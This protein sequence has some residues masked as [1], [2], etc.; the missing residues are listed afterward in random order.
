MTEERVLQRAFKP[1]ARLLQL[2]G[3]QLIGSPRLALFEL[4][5]NAYDADANEV[6]ITFQ[7]LGT[8]DA[9][10]SIRDNGQ[11]MSLETIED[12]WLVPGDDHRERD[13]GSNIRSPRYGRLPLG[14]KGVGRFAVHKLGDSINLVTRAEGQ[15]ECVARFDWDKLLEETY[16]SDAQITVRERVPTVFT[17][18]TGTLIEVGRLRADDWTRGELRDLYRQ[19]TSIA[20]PFGERVDDFEVKLEVP[21][22]PEWLATLPSVQQLLEMAP[23]RL[24]SSLTETNCVIDMNLWA[25]LG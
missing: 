3:D 13:R 8:P 14:E 15:P 1:R 23:Y 5:K 20:S 7:N 17:S 22:H 21:Q 6:T 18:G 19:V 24:N 11:G 4:V 10:I 12:I 9:T 25:F 16:L 2:L